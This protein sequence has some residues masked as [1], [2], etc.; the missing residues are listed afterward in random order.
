MTNFVNRLLNAL[1][2]GETNSR[3][4]DSFKP[5]SMEGLKDLHGDLMRMHVLLV[6]DKEYN[7]S[8]TVL[9]TAALIQQ[10]MTQP[11]SQAKY[12]RKSKEKF[13]GMWGGY[14]SLTDFYIANAPEGETEARRT[15]FGM[16]TGAISMFYQDD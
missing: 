8:K 12:L 7:F 10:A 1:G 3:M 9:E 14:G 15:E 13:M 16:V 2:M 6:E 11:S 4:N 5:V